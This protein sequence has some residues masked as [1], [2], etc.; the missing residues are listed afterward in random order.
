[1]KMS[2][3]EKSTFTDNVIEYY[4]KGN[5]MVTL[6]ESEEVDKFLKWL[7]VYPNQFVEKNLRSI[8]S[9]EMYNSSY[10]PEEDKFKASK[11]IIRMLCNVYLTQNA[12][13]TNLKEYFE[14][15]ITYPNYFNEG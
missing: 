5:I 1:M 4:L 12:I 15:D 6:S 14:S 11:E 8:I 13:D 7:K 3:E 9:F 2:E 10:I